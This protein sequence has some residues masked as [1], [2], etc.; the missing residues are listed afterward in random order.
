MATGMSESDA[1][2]FVAGLERAL[3]LKNGILVDERK[4]EEKIM[5]R[6]EGDEEEDEKGVKNNGAAGRTI[7]ALV[8]G[9]GM[10]G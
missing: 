6:K 8:R 7:R 4:L 1:G 5:S 9:N 3:D 2:A 10:N